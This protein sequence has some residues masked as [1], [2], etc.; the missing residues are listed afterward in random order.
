[1]GRDDLLSEKV[2]SLLAQFVK[3]NGPLRPP[4]DP[5]QLAELCGVLGIEHRP[6]IPEG[7]LTPVEGGFRIYLQSNFAQQR[8]VSP[9][10]RFTVAHELAHTFYYELSG[11]IPKQAKGSPRGSALE[12]LCHIGAGRILIPDVLLKREIE[13]RGEVTS[14]EAILDLAKVFNVSVEVLIRRLHATEGMADYNFAAIFVGAI[15]EGKRLIRAACYSPILLC[16]AVHPRTGMDFG[17]WVRQLLP[18][19]G[20]P[21]AAEWT[22]TTRQ[23]TVVAKK[24]HRSDGSF[25]L[26]LN[27]SQ[28]ANRSSSRP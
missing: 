21:E 19:S 7:V 15:S 1:M 28:L 16:N 27:F 12:R 2:Q 18:P 25:I 9:R 11:G 17:N 3:A 5:T 22:H 4:I 8:D 13:A 24:L 6:M 10:Q 23:T 14:V 20:G 26:G